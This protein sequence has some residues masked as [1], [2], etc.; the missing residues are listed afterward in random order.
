MKAF[1]LLSPLGLL[2]PTRAFMVAPSR[3][4]FQSALYYLPV[5][6]EKTYGSETQPIADLTDVEAAMEAFFDAN[7]EWNPVFRSVAQSSSV[8]AMRYL[9]GAHGDPIE[10]NEQTTPWKRLEPTPS[11]REDR[12]VIADFLDSIQQSLVDIPV[13]EMVKEDEFDRHFVEEGRRM[14]AINRCHVVRTTEGN[15]AENYEK[16]FTTCWSELLELLTHNE[17]N[18]GSLIIL[19]N[20]DPS[21]LRQFANMNLQRPLEWLGM[22]DLFEISSFQRGCPAIRLLHNLTSVKSDVEVVF[23]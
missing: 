18:T 12:K 21:R 20:Y 5:E 10:F 14:L 23:L 1:C 11:D 7:E 2:I 4:S 9:G 6:I 3:H 17:P 13:N 8:P 19:P 15:I 16:M 22:Q